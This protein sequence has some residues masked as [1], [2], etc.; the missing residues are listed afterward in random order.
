MTV[1]T[2]PPGYSAPC[3]SEMLSAWG[4]E[5][6]GVL[7]GASSLDFW[8]GNLSLQWGVIITSP[9]RWGDV[10][11]TDEGAGPR[12]TRGTSGCSGRDWSLTCRRK[13]ILCRLKGPSFPK[14]TPFSRGSLHPVTGKCTA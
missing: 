7:E 12:N 8:E 1:L 14:V 6:E 9:G 10:G 5:G 3:C 4:K 11:R 2:P 13:G